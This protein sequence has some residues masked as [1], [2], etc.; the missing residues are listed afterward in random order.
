LA[1]LGVGNGLRI[2]AGE[3]FVGT[4]FGLSLTIEDFRVAATFPT[5][6][7]G[8]LLEGGVGLAER[9]NFFPRGAVAESLRAA[10]L[11]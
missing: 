7:K 11:E 2:T 3:V 5:G 4:G 8:G 9:S 1:R 10:F 6:L